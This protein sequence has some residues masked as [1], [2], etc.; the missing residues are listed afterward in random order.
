[1]QSTEPKRFIVDVGGARIHRHKDPVIHSTPA[2][3]PAS[4]PAAPSITREYA[5]R[6][7]ETCAASIQRTGETKEQAVGRF[8]ATEQGWRLYASYR[9]APDAED[10][11]PASAAVVA[12]PRS[13]AEAK[14]QA[15]ADEIKASEPNMTD[16]QAYAKA[17]ERNPQLYAEHKAGR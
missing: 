15:K 5:W 16:A 8:L 13:N 14:L 4:A 11:S 9:V 1:M 7:I 6:Q 3:Q 10:A 12:V 2:S 17:I